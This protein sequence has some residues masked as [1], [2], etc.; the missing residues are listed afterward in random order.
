[1]SKKKVTTLLLS[2]VLLG[3]ITIGIIGYFFSKSIISK[4]NNQN[5]L[6]I[7]YKK[8]AQESYLKNHTQEEFMKRYHRNYL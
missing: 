1:M 3:S 6:D 5:E 8:L 4:N 7:K 2:L